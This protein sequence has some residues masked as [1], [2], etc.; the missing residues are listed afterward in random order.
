MASKYFKKW[1]DKTVHNARQTLSDLPAV[2]RA[3]AALAAGNP[4]P[5]LKYGARRVYNYPLLKH[6]EDRAYQIVPYGPRK[7]FKPNLRYDLKMWRTGLENGRYRLLTNGFC[8]CYKQLSI[9]HRIFQYIFSF[10]T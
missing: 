4:V 6:K 7:R 5:L 3:A 1:A 10:R 2:G 8:V 9:L